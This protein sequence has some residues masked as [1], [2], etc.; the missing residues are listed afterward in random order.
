MS[1]QYIELA[2]LVKS[3][4]NVRKTASATADEELK[5]SIVA[6]G[7]MQNLVVTEGKKGKYLVIAGARRLEAMKSLQAEGKLP[8]DHAVPCQV[9]SEEHAAEMSL[10][11]N[12]V[13]QAM[14]PADEF[15]AFAA[16]S[17]AGKSAGFIAERF[18]VEEKHVLK[19]L[20]LG[21][22]ALELLAEYR[23]ENLTLEVLMAF[24]VTD[25]QTRQMEVYKSLDKWDK[26]NEHAV[27]RALTEGT[28]SG[29]DKLAKFVGLEAYT[30]AGG[31]TK[32]DLFGDRVYLENPDVLHRLA[33][34]KLEAAAEELRGE[35]WAWVE[36]A[37]E[38]DWD[39]TRRCGS[40][41]S[42]PVDAPQELTDLK[43]KL[44]TESEAADQAYYED[45][46]EDEA[47]SETL[48]AKRDVLEKQ[49]GE[50]NEKLESYVVFDPE[51]MKTAGC[52]VSID[53]NGTLRIEKGLVRPED[54]KAAAKAKGADA[55][56]DEPEKPKGMS[57]SLKRYLEAYRLSVAQAE[58]AKH[59]AIAFDLLVFKAAKNALTARST[60]DGPQVSFSRNFAGN[61]SADASGFIR[62]QMEPLSKAL[63]TD[64]LK[65]K[66]EAAQFA[67][68]QGLSDYQKQALLAYSVALTLQPKLDNGGELTA[69]DVALSQTG[70]NVAEYWRPTKD[71][72]L[73]RVTK[74]QLLEIGRELVG[75]DRGEQWARNNA[76]AK[77][78]DIAGELHKV[79]NEPNRPG[80]T[81]EQGERIKNWLP[82]G[83]AF[84][85]A[86]E[87]TPTKAKKGKKAA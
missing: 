77:K 38:H 30:A 25:D 76:N 5:S 8:E 62:S 70:A 54:K 61:A 51:E 35:G 71:A 47:L 66:T 67:A 7:L 4:L 26:K 55:E 22:L 28:V 39:F 43:A 32:N 59:P 60:Y 27:R 45:D 31:F 11:E 17:K 79:F 13:R 85:E 46:G 74:D 16:L 36:T 82:E 24:T 9:V 18:G 75:G 33:G 40:I 12:I 1:N 72:Y 68:F 48:E 78:G 53:G 29:N 6:H 3:P 10:A 81:P 49:L 50:L 69:Y 73:G 41:E 14:H 65:G 2:K 58:I 80:T 34:E 86:P 52:Y 23:A 57:E 64:W 63:P 87:P 83:M 42:S 84:R 37:I 20:R 15:E 21:K 44:E 19:R 56:P